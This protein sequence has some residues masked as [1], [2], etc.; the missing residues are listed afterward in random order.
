MAMRTQSPPARP[1]RSGNEAISIHL[2]G[3]IHG[4][5]FELTG[6]V[7]SVRTDYAEILGRPLN[8]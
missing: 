7:S 1:V 4:H 5:P 2:G 3:L 6:N 8:S